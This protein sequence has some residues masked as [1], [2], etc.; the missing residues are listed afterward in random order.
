MSSGCSC[1]DCKWLTM[2]EHPQ[3]KQ[4]M[5]E[6]M[7]E[8]QNMQSRND[9]WP[10]PEKIA[11]L[12]AGRVEAQAEFF[13]RPEIQ[14]H[15]A[16]YQAR[17]ERQLAEQKLTLES[18][19]TVEVNARIRERENGERYLEMLREAAMRSL[20]FQDGQEMQA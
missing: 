1:M 7:T 5:K 20:S 18:G 2:A 4:T 6:L 9:L 12:V 19:L 14:A 13:S 10:T 3:F 8:Y 11:E 17:K 16:E 15:F